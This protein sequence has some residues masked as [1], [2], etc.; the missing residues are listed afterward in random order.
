MAEKICMQFFVT[1]RVQGVWFRAG[2]KQEAERL[3]LLGFAKNLP[4]G[5]VEV[6]A[7][8]ER[9]KLAALNE[10]LKHGPRGAKVEGLSSEELP[11]QAYTGFQTL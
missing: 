1:G 3:G 10:W 4:D 11:W 6:I 2:T 9:D 7:C 5:R 8:G